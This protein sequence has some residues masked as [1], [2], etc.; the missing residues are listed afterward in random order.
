MRSD[1]EIILSIS[2]KRGDYVTLEDG[3]VY[4]WPKGNG[5]MAAWHL[6]ALADEIDR[7]NE[8][9]DKIVQYGLGTANE[10]SG[11]Q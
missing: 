6:R 2:E 7:R 5:A 8:D 11:G 10:P 4:F 9:W 3:Y 1:K